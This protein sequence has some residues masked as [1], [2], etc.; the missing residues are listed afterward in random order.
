MRS[1]NIVLKIFIAV[2]VLAL[3]SPLLWAKMPKELVKE[4]TDRVLAI[5]KDPSLKGPEKKQELKHK[6]LKEI[7]LAIDFEEISKRALG[8]YWRERSAEEKKEFVDLFSSMVQDFYMDRIAAYSDEKI[9][10]LGEEQDNDY[11]T[12]QTKIIAK[13]GTE[14]T[15]DYRLFN[16]RGEWRVYD[17]NVEGVSL[18]NN[19]RIQFNNTVVKSS[20][21]K[22]VEKMKQKKK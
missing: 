14:I 15:V 2:F 4:T 16:E 21:E 22:L 10:Y 20:Y 8:P 6:L 13:T 9:V 1:R 5:L 11:S 3:M 19:Y 7:S 18:V 12:V 17:I